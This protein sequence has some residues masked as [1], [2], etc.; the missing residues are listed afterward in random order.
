[1][2][3]EVK[4]RPGSNEGDV[5]LFPTSDDRWRVVEI[6]E[7]GSETDEAEMTNSRSFSPGKPQFSRK[8]EGILTPGKE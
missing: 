3:F 6:L 7:N 4:L 5:E 8:S 2:V 1:M